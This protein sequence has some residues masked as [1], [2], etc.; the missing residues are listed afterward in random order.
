MRSIQVYFTFYL[1][2]EE[3]L[4]WTMLDRTSDLLCFHVGCGPQW[5]HILC[6]ASG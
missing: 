2:N 6:T 3:F 1:Q 4:E 5:G